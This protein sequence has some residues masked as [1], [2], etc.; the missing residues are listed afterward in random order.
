MFL[1]LWTDWAK[2]YSK[3]VLGRFVQDRQVLELFGGQSMKVR[4][5]PT[6]IDILDQPGEFRI[7]M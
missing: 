5:I 3:V 4:G 7:V 2:G 1:V 6:L